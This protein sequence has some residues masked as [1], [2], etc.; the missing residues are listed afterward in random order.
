MMHNMI[1]LIQQQTSK[2]R[3]EQTVGNHESSGVVAGFS[4]GNDTYVIS[5]QGHPHALVW[6][7]HTRERS[8]EEEQRLNEL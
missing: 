8:K 2:Q 3:S 4:D 6:S 7:P 5:E 1:V